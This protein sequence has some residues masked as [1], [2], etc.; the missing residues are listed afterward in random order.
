VCLA[1][2]DLDAPA[3]AHGEAAT[4]SP[5]QPHTLAEDV[6][7]SEEACRA[8][9]VT[10]R[11]VG[12]VRRATWHVRWFP[13]GTA[14]VRRHRG[15]PNVVWLACAIAAMALDVLAVQ[16]FVRTPAGRAET[17]RLLRLLGERTGGRW[18]ARFDDCRED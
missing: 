12:G 6:F 14:D 5:T 18:E 8:A 3:R 7:E 9:E 4:A 16:E 13:Q 15:A 10:P 2:C 17:D 11:P 1:A